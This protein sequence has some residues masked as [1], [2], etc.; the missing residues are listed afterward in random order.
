MIKFI[1]IVKKLFICFVMHTINKTHNEVQLFCPGN[2]SRLLGVQ[3]QEKGLLLI[4]Y[5]AINP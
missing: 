2:N 4:Y 1:K 5:H 3:F